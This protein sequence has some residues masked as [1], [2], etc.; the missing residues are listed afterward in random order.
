MRVLLVSNMWPTADEPWFGCFVKEQAE[1]LPALGIFVRVV[2][3]DGRRSRIN[4]L[5][6]ARKLRTL[7]A[8]ERFDL[9]HAHYGLTG[10]V[11][12][13]QRSVPV[14]TTFHGSDTGYV[15]WQRYVSWMVARRSYP[16]F[17]SESGARSLGC[18]GAQILPAPVDTDL[19]A[20]CERS[21][22]RRELGWSED[23]PYVL[24]PGSRRNPVKRAD[25]FDAA[26]R[27]AQRAAPD[28]KGVSLEGYSRREAALVMNAVDVTLM[29]SDSEGSP[30]AVRES[31][32]CLTPVVSVPVGDVPKVL[33]DLPGCAIRSREPVAL[34]DGVVHALAAPRD[35]AL[36]E[37]AERYSRRR[38]TE[39]LAVIYESVAATRRGA[40][41]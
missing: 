5:R 32:A 34:A 26:V 31:L 21:A 36:R 41:L 20:P 6:T 8:R 40:R 25:L 10:A 29:T 3:F 24:L 33:R 35:P 17:V 27:E 4:Y 1:D 13:F 19:F 9:V 39:R 16:V 30:V 14:I 22:A 18:L 37:R 28:L 23:H 15:A 7:V 11:S 12:L 38:T 2:H